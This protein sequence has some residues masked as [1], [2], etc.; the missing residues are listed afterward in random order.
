M[1]DL[2]NKKYDYMASVC[3]RYNAH[4]DWLSFTPGHYSPVMPTGR[5]R[6]MQ[7]RKGKTRKVIQS[8]TTFALITWK[9][10]VIQDDK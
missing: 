5:L 2:E 6:I 3:S 8:Q 10:V 4:S 1:K 7:I 9:I